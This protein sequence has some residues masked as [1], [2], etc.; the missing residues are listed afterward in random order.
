MIPLLENPFYNPQKNI[1]TANPS[2]WQSTIIIGTKIESQTQNFAPKNDTDWSVLLFYFWAIGAVVHS[3]LLVKNA[4]QLYFLKK[5]T[6][7]HIHPVANYYTN[8]NTP[9][10]FSFGKTIFLHN[11]TYTDSDLQLILQHE[12]SHYQHKHWIDNV[13]LE[14]L[15]IIF[16]VHPL[17][18]IFKRQVKL[19]HEYEVDADI[20]TSDYY[21]YGKLL[22]AQNNKTYKTVLIHTF[23]YSPLKKRIVMMTKTKKANKWKFAL[24]A[25]LL[26]L[27]FLMMATTP[28]S[29]ERIRTGNVTKFKGNTIEWTGESSEIIEVVDPKTGELVKTEVKTEDHIIKCNGKKIQKL[30]IVNYSDFHG[31][32]DPFAKTIANNI[33]LRLEK[34]KGNLPE[35]IAQLQLVNLILDKNGNPTYYDVLTMGANPTDTSISGFNKYPEVNKIVEAILNDKKIVNPTNLKSNY[36]YAMIRVGLAIKTI[37][38]NVRKLTKEETK[39]SERE[40]EA[41]KML[42]QKKKDE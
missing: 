37:S 21:E 9:T 4:F 12:K 5:Y 22:L 29:D 33:Y 26:G 18:P 20:A 13:L 28:K 6:K 1:A 42:Q 10:A 32:A 15:Q 14:M 41:R 24:A 36:E 27:C 35:E 16:W 39:Q 8:D 17:F 2:I 34:I 7:L 25:P 23:N 30:E 3:F 31:Y 11:E 40:K 38:F 19:V